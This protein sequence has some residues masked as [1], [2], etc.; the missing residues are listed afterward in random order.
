MKDRLYTAGKKSLSRRAYQTVLYE[1]FQTLIRFLVPVMPHQAEDIFAHTPDCQKQGLSSIL[2]SEWPKERMEWMSAEI[3]DKWDNILKIR[4]LVTKAIEPL[5]INKQVGSSL[6]VAVYIKTTDELQK[7]LINSKDDLSTIFIVSQV[8]V[9]G[10]EPENTLNTL[11]SGETEIKVGHAIGEKCERC[12]KYRKL[13]E[14]ADYPT[15][16]SD[17]ASSL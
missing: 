4:E 5:R 2:L 15:L 11:Q 12:W 13:G 14:N 9:E 10:E 8:F 6:E 3:N 1:I 7:A 16:C 17:C